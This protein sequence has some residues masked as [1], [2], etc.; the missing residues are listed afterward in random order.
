LGKG[1]LI[2]FLP[3]PFNEELGQLGK[4]LNRSAIAA[5]KAVSRA[6]G[7]AVKM[8]LMADQQRNQ[9]DPCS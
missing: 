8:K 6:L 4:N 3:Q 1:S 7:T 2:R 5:A 9:K